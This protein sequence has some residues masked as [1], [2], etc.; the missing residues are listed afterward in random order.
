MTALDELIIVDGAGKEL[1]RVNDYPNGITLFIDANDDGYMTLD[2]RF[3]SLDDG[4]VAAL[5]DWLNAR[6]EQR[7][8]VAP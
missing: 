3:T 7:K 4:G 8:E 6:L 5:A 2:A 1:L